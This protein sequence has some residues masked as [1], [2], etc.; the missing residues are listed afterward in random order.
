MHEQGKSYGQLRGYAR[1]QNAIKIKEENLLP[2]HLR[3]FALNN[4]S[5]EKRFTGNR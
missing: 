3:Q 1:K 2:R 5:S 4:I